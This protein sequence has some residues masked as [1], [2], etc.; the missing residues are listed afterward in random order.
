MISAFLFAQMIFAKEI[1]PGSAGQVASGFFSERFSVAE[2]LEQN[3]VSRV[4]F[5]KGGTTFYVFNLKDREGFIIVSGDDVLPPVPGY[6]FSGNFDTDEQN[7]AFDFWMKGL[8][9]YTRRHQTGKFK[10]AW[11]KYLSG[12]CSAK[13][14]PLAKRAGI[15]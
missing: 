3:L 10:A 1:T 4:T 14:M 2:T 9:D 13:G 12:E 6:S 7:D 5:T 11:E 8:S 15:T